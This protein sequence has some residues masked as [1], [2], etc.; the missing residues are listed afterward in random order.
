MSLNR[1]QFIKMLWTYGNCSCYVWKLSALDPVGRCGRCKEVP[2]IISADK[3]I[4]MD[5]FIE[6]NGYVPRRMC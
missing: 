2:T 4:A 6:D 5:K 1:L 3:R